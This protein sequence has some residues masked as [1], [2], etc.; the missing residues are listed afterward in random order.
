MGY[1]HYWDASPFTDE[2]WAEVI[3]RGKRILS[4]ASHIPVQ[5]EY[6][7]PAP[8]E[9]SQECIRFNGVDEDG[10]ETFVVGP[11]DTGFGF[12]KTARKPYDTVVVA[13]LVMLNDVNPDFTWSS[14][15]EDEDHE[16]GRKLYEE[17]K[18]GEE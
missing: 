5:F 9:L 13:F 16:A 1:T 10:H 7:T 15:G 8:P 11:R 12:C 3:E 6:D 4:C 14:D 17:S 2:Q 18:Q